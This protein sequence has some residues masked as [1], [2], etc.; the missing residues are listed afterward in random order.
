MTTQIPELESIYERVFGDKV[1]GLVIDVGAYDGLL[2]SNSLPLIKRGWSALLY[3][4]IFYRECFENMIPYKDRVGVKRLAMGAYRGMVKMYP[5]D[6]Y[7]T[8]SD[9]HK[10]NVEKAGWQTFS[11]PVVVMQD[12]LDNQFNVLRLHG[13][14][15]LSIDVEGAETAVLAGWDTRMYPAK[16]VIIEAHALHPIPSFR[17]RANDIMCWMKERGYDLLYQDAINDIYVRDM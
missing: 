16:M 6:V 3:E 13:C 2:Y 10:E 12:T 8:T 15:V 9:E 11:A 1:D 7:S 5:G 14:D 4:P 17:M